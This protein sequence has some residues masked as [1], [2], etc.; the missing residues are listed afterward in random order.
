MTRSCDALFPNPFRVSFSHGAAA[1]PPSGRAPQWR[2]AAPPR[3]MSSGEGQCGDAACS[4]PASAKRC[5]VCTTLAAA[6]NKIRR[7]SKL[8]LQEALDLAE[9]QADIGRPLWGSQF[10]QIIKASW[11]T[12]L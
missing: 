8:Q 7:V 3:P 10:G 4:S 2:L 9:L 11:Q 12:E 1:T 6:G 5:F